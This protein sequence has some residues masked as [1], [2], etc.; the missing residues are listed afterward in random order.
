MPCLARDTLRIEVTL[1]VPCGKGSHEVVLHLAPWG[2]VEVAF[3]PCELL[4]ATARRFSGSSCAGGVAQRALACERALQHIWCETGPTLDAQV[5]GGETGRILA[6]LNEIRDA[7]LALAESLLPGFVPTAEQ[8]AD[9]LSSP[10]PAVQWAAAV[11]SIG[12]FEWTP[13]L[14]SLVAE[15]PLF[16][17]LAVLWGWAK[18]G[19]ERGAP[20]LADRLS[21]DRIAP[22]I[23]KRFA[24]KLGLIGG[25]EVAGALSGASASADS[26]VAT[27]ASRGLSHLLLRLHRAADGTEIRR[28]LRAAFNHA[29]AVRSRAIGLVQALGN[30]VVA[31]LIAVLASGPEAS[32]VG[33]ART[34]GLIGDCRA[35]GP[36]IDA[37][38]AAETE[39]RQAAAES[40]LIFLP[41]LGQFGGNGM[42]LLYR[43]LA[44]PHEAV[45]AA[46]C[47]S[48]AEVRDAQAVPH[49]IQTLQHTA[50]AARAAA[51]KAL[52][53][54]P[55]C[56]AVEPLIDL[57]TRR[58]PAATLEAANALRCIIH[59]LPKRFGDRPEDAL[60]V[61]RRMLAAPDTSVCLAGLR[62]LGESGL[63]AAVPLLVA[64]LDNPDPLVRTHALEA[65]RKT[66][67]EEAVRALLKMLEH[68]D[69]EVRQQAA[70]VIRTMLRELH[71]AV[72]TNVDLL[73]E[74]LS[75][76]H[77]GTAIQAARA[78][79]L[80][81]HPRAVLPLVRA[82]LRGDLELSATAGKALRR[83][84]SQEQIE[85]LASMLELGDDC[86][87]RSVAAALIEIGPR[88]L[89]AIGKVARSPLRRARQL[90][91]ET[92]GLI[93]DAAAAGI[94][95]HA[96]RDREPAVRGAAEQALARVQRKSP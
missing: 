56:Q 15:Q 68:P 46:A 54:M 50:G 43:A 7:R 75:A 74:V 53:Q 29:P 20:L 59:W 10:D 77:A 21:D 78:L 64:A 48:L 33:A 40:L 8:L 44:T 17:Q 12:Q 30:A 93:G 52:G 73:L 81:G 69:K 57:L 6:F 82:C 84:A 60:P 5:F 38:S 72:P 83:L 89:A 61:L 87:A 37:V 2:T 65:I 9:S 11:L 18:L 39:L 4:P 36:L 16:V 28:A 49:L 35:V 58:D 63:P 24:E 41:A 66:G 13:D 70:D 80:A 31:P 79:G 26:I 14:L 51:A 62:R 42:A 32:R 1:T 23:R 85:S 86:T 67:R 91:V 96:R 92:L 45:V 76:P 95:Q 88:S 22:P 55:D 90:A 71:S 27:A 47:D 25:A 19:D 94:L 34:L 3:N